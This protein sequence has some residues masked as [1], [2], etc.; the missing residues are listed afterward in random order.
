MLSLTDTVI[1][2]H[3][4]KMEKSRTKTHIHPESLRWN[5]PQWTREQLKFG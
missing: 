3:H 4:R 5:P 2:Q 1:E